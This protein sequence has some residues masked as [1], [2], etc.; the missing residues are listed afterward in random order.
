MNQAARQG[1]LFDL[2]LGRALK[3]RA[4]AGF[5]EKAA[6]WLKR[7][8]QAAREVCRRKGSATSDDVLAEVGLPD[9]IHHN[10]VGA[11]FREP[12]WVRAGFVRT[13]R[14]EGHARLIS[15][16]RLRRPTRR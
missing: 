11:I 15:V 13:R 7:A 4:H 10:V 2:E 6:W 8:R 9:G 16:W 12:C 5:E 1:V 14:P 3:D